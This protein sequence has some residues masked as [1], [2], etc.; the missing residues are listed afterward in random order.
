MASTHEVKEERNETILYQ[1]VIPQWVLPSPVYVNTLDGPDSGNYRLLLHMNLVH[2]G[3][4]DLHAS[5][6]GE[7]NSYLSQ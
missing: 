5:T 7:L 1:S 2:H 3:Q 6:D 4:S